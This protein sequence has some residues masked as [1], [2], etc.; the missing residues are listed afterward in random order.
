MRGHWLAF[1]VLGTALAGCSSEEPDSSAPSL[2]VEPDQHAGV[3]RE[4]RLDVEFA[5]EFDGTS[6]EWKESTVIPTNVTDLR[7]EAMFVARAPAWESGHDQGDLRVQFGTSSSAE[8]IGPWEWTCSG[9]SATWGCISDGQSV[10]TPAPSGEYRMWI[11]GGQIC[12]NERPN[13][14]LGFTIET[15]RTTGRIEVAIWSRG[16]CDGSSS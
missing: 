3:Q 9:V 2:G 8:P 6:Q 16:D 11:G 14:T 13:E 15:A 10:Q 4:G 12:R 5:R 7:F 1:M